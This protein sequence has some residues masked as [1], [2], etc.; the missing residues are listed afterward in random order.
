MRGWLDWI[1]IG[2]LWLR[3]LLRV[4]GGGEEGSEEE[5]DGQE[6]DEEDEAQ[7]LVQAALEVGGCASLPSHRNCARAS[8]YFFR[9][10]NKCVGYTFWLN[11][12][13]PLFER[14]LGF[15]LLKG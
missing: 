3:L 13:D 12:F 8:T 10:K 15:N 1:G 2:R 4:A 6:G 11:S 9:L 5:S 7:H 14:G